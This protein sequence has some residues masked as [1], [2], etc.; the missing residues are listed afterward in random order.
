VREWVEGSDYAKALG[1]LLDELTEDQ[2][3]LKLPFREGNS[4]PGGALHGGCAASLG[5]I[6]SQVLARQS[7]GAERGPFV[8]VSVHVSYLAAAI[9]EDVVAVSRLARRGKELCFV[10]TTV[11][12][13][14]AKPVSLAVAVVAARSGAPAPTL[15]AAEGDDGDPDPGAMGP[16]I[17]ALPFIGGRQI[18]VRHMKDGRSRLVMPLGD[19]NGGD[20]GRFHEGAVFALLDTTGAMAAWSVTGPGP[21]KASTPALQGQVL[22]LGDATT[23]RGYGRVVQRDGDLFTS[24]VEVADPSGRLHARGTVIYRIVS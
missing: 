22:G 3:R 15:R 23:L 1:V 12:T 10:Q 13:L 5:L 11:E 21:F 14:E 7:L 20:S 24:D 16:A 6:G 18:R 9:N 19:A 8:T 4:N 2:V 17:E